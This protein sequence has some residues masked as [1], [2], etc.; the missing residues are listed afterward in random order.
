MKIIVIEHDA[1]VSDTIALYLQD[2]FEVATARDG[3][4]GLSSRAR[5]TRVWSPSVRDGRGYIADPDPI[6]SRF[7]RRNS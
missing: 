4:T 2:G 6:S 7:T 1:V 5:P 3:V